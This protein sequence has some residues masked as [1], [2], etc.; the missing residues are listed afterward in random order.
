M[1][2]GEED[3]EKTEFMTP[4]HLLEMCVTA[5][6]LCNSQATYQRVMDKTLEGTEL[7]DSFVD[8]IL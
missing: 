7:A 2:I 1:P 4:R 8:N 3:R 5:S 6:G